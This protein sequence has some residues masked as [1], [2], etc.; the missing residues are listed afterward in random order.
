MDVREGCDFVRAGAGA[1][2][3][4]FSE[5]GSEADSTEHGGF[6]RFKRDDDIMK[7]PFSKERTCKLAS[8]SLAEEEYDR[9]EARHQRSQLLAMDAYSRHKKF[10]RDYLLY[11]GGKM[12][13]FQRSTQ[14]DKS[15]LD[16]V[17]ENHRFLWSA[18]DEKDM[19]WE[20]T[21]AKKYYDKLFKEYCIA[22]LSRYKEN[23]IGLRWQI[24]KEVISGKGQ[25]FCGNKHCERQDELR[26]WEVNFAYKER[27]EKKN[28]LVK[29]RLCP[30]C[31]FKLNHHHK[32]KE[33][34]KS[35]RKR[36][37]KDKSKKY[38]EHCP[39]GEEGESSVS[40]AASSVLRSKQGPAKEAH[41]GNTEASEMSE[42]DYWKNLP[43]TEQEKS[44]EEEF[45]DYFED[46]FL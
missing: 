37:K 20:K 39:L 14:K 45:D 30:D 23:K 15:E 33:I 4:E 27:G 38:S 8:K 40:G 1:Y 24:E 12:E 6:K 13:D 21:L 29:L 41:D 34:K 35:K 11:Y 17:R 18:D 42:S 28:A 31:S 5:Y 3:S 43:Q 16:V 25:F 7:K 2:D 46:M 22:D 19:T 44:R 36:E 26:S 32:R 10:V 9:Q